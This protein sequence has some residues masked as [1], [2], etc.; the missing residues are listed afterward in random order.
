MFNSDALFPRRAAMARR[1]LRPVVGETEGQPLLLLFQLNDCSSFSGSVEAAGRT[2][3]ITYVT[4]RLSAVSLAC[5]R[6]AVVPLCVHVMINLNTN[7][8]WFSLVG[9]SSPVCLVLC[10]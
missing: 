1:F 3:G 8:S 10:G 9:S 6:V 5:L 4:Q 7:P 2:F